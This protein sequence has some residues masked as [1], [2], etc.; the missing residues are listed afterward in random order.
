MP[1]Y[2]DPKWLKVVQGWLRKKTSVEEVEAEW[3]KEQARG[4][5]AEVRRPLG[6]INAQ[7][8]TFK[9]QMQPGDELWTFRSDDGSWKMLAGREGYALVRNGEVIDEIVTVLS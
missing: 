2:T 7:W 5:R 6:F 1:R 9:A 8:E 4:L 3:A